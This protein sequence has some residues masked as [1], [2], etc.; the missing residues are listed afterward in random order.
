V[1]L[2]LV[3]MIRISSSDLSG[4]LTWV[5]KLLLDNPEW[6]DRLQALGSDGQGDQ[7]AE[8]ATLMLREMLR[9]ERSEFIF[10]KTRTEIVFKGYRIPRGW[11]V[12]ICIRD[13]H[14]DPRIFPDPDA[15][16]PMRFSGKAWGKREY[17][18]LGI[19]AHACLGGQAINVIGR[20]FL[21]ELSRT[22]R[23]SVVSDGEREYGRS[24]WQPASSWRIAR[25]PLDEAS[26]PLP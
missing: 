6:F 1:L 11:I 22:F 19:G 21:L 15:F 5:V 24:H 7:A 16:D 10:R 20:I 25:A 4:F 13:G 2:N 12:R 26:T 8:L 17:S 3:Y 9:L 14:R 18:P 23:A